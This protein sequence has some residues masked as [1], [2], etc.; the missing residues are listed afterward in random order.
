MFSQKIQQSLK[1]RY[2]SEKV[3]KFSG[4]L[5][6]IIAIAFLVVLFSAVIY[7]GTP[8]FV[9]HKIALEVD[10]TQQQ[11][12]YQKV[13]KNALRAKFPEAQTR[14]QKV[15]LYRTLSEIAYLTLQEKVKKNP[16]L[17]GKKTIMRFPVS[18]DVDMFLKGKILE[19]TPNEVRKLKDQQ[20]AWIKILQS[21]NAISSNFNWNFFKYAD[22]A[23][24]EIAGMAASIVGSIL[25]IIIFL[26]AAFP[27]AVMAAFYL[28]EFAPKNILTDIV[29]VS[30][31]NLAAIPSI[32][33][34]LLGFVVYL[35][36]MHLPRS[37]SIVGGLTLSMLV[38]PIIIIATRNTIK[39]IPSSIKEAAVAMGASKVQVMFHH[40]LPLS[41]P[42]IMTGTILAISRAL[43]ETAPLL[44]IGMVAFI[45]DV[46]QS[47][48]D[49][50]TVMPVQ[51]YLWSDSPELGF[52]EKSAAAIM[53][54]L[55]FLISFNGVAVYIR[56]RF[57]KK[58]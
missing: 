40:T 6:V 46:P 45:A 16:D 8:A 1:K 53:V 20:I 12:N 5:A 17:I 29:E 36:F 50:T 39:T 18:S 57:E 22:S 28:E 23:E 54:L 3:F 34:G 25:T 48:L 44:M 43:G 33:F 58:W 51:I 27:I 42:G 49:P 37:S 9:M 26:L 32:I 35:N 10:L 13:I 30:I 31:N 41:L 55:A 4:L 24:P 11:N 47:F 52:A 7:R 14:T 2:R 15:K 21:E 19:S 38:L 56:K